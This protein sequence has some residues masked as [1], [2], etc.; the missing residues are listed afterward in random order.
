MVRG[1]ERFVSR[2]GVELLR[3]Q[4]GGGGAGAGAGAGRCNLGFLLPG[5]SDSSTLCLDWRIT[6]VESFLRGI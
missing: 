1:K 4:R 5:S 3:G 6:E 2:P